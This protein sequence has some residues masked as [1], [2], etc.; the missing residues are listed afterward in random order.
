MS[1]DILVSFAV[2]RFARPALLRAPWPWL[3]PALWL[4]LSA[5]TSPA[6]DDAAVDDTPAVVPREAW[7]VEDDPR[8]LD[9]SFTYV[10]GELPTSGLVEQMPWPGSYWP[11]SLDG[12]NYRWAGPNTQSPAEKYALAFGKAG[13]ED[14]VSRHS[15]VDSLPT[16]TCREESDC[17]E[18]EVCAR[19][20]GEESGRC[21][22]LWT[23]I[24]HAWAPAA[25]LER[26]PRR[27]VT[28]RGVRFEINDLKAL[29]SMAYTEG[30]S[31]RLVSLR[32]DED[33]SEHDLD[34]IDEC[35]DT[36]PG[37]FHVAVANLLGLRRT[38][39]ILDRT[40]DAEVQNYPVVAYHV[41]R[42]EPIS[43]AEANQRLGAEGSDYA[44]ND[45]AVELRLLR[46][47]L[48]WVS[49]SPAELDGFLSPYL[50][51]FTFIDVYDYIVELDKDGEII[52]GEW[53]GESRTRHPDFLWIP[54]EK[55]DV[56]VAGIEYDDVEHLMQLAG[57]GR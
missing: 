26:E 46:T 49:T 54:E 45:R 56:A 41:A 2:G 18:E 44:F 11:S 17:E 53:L 14:A 10:F 29:I 20:R 52:G 38:A 13:V 55:Y 33:G 6:D 48:A 37:T 21:A 7:S 43:S 34:D 42:D 25:L 57:G 32:C 9:G 51:H 8:L 24:C 5:C 39:F 23:G 47:E 36:N 50:E 31:V 16:A 4:S 22:P 1:H 19:R 3:T 12:I 27:P 35:R 40:Y 30:L 15:G 28:Y